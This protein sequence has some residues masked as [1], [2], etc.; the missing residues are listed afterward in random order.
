MRFSLFSLLDVYD[1]EARTSVAIYQQTLEQ[2]ALADELGFDSYWIGEHHG[3]L[4][5]D[6]L[7][8]CPNPAILL[9]AAAKLTQR[10]GLNTAVANLSLRH[11]LQ[12]A[13]DYALVDLLS[14][15]RLG[16]GIGR[17]SF[18]HEY[19]AIGQDAA[20]SFGR[21]EE[22]WEIIQ[23]L[24][25]GEQVTFQGR[26]SQL[27]N[28]K[29]NVTPVQQPF[30]RHWF[31]AIKGDSFATR[32]RAAQPVIGLPHI[33]AKNFADAQKLVEDH[34]S[35]YLAAGGDHEHYEL[36]LILYTFVAPTRSEALHVAVDALR[37]YMEHQ[38]PGSH[39]HIMHVIHHL[40]D[41]K[42]LWFGTPGDLIEVIA[43]F[44]AHIDPR[45][46]VFW[47]DFG[48]LPPALVLRSMR[49]IAQEVLPHFTG[50]MN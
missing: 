46:V 4:T 29:L 12:L 1:T 30:P 47:S 37:R 18:T 27:E 50:Q 32:G 5:P 23:R 34:R 36:P 28:A 13:E 11:P 6:Q 19:A 20:E 24:W 40:M 15:G 44:Q 48:G 43:Q 10:I 31:S 38:H 41:Q 25:R 8:A 2:M 42:L 22:S 14:Q 35:H 33:S 26:Y 45:H 17:G 7:L 49:L 9:A 16:L 3:Y 21:F 39:E